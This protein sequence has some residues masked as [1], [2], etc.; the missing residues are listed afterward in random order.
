MFGCHV[1]SLPRRR[2]ACLLLCTLRL[3]QLERRDEY[4]HEL[5]VEV[6]VRRPVVPWLVLNIRRVR[7]ARRVIQRAVRD[8]VRIR[9]RVHRVVGHAGNCGKWCIDTKAF[10]GRHAVPGAII[11]VDFV[12]TAAAVI[13]VVVII[14]AVV[15]F[16][17]IRHERGVHATTPRAGRRTRLVAPDERAVLERKLGLT[18]SE[19]LGGEQPHLWRPDPVAR[20]GAG[21]AEVDTLD[22]PCALLVLAPRRRNLGVHQAAPHFA[23]GYVRAFAGEELARRGVAAA[24]AGVAA[25][26]FAVERVEVPEFLRHTG[27]NRVLAHLGPKHSE[28]SFRRVAGGL[29][30]VRVA[31]RLL[32]RCCHGVHRCRVEHY[33]VV[34]VQRAAGVDVDTE[35]FRIQVILILRSRRLAFGLHGVDAEVGRRSVATAQDV[36][37]AEHGLDWP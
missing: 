4:L 29:V 20:L 32:M 22:P 34:A 12:V 6:H 17:Q 10:A 24:H 11:I 33:L 36:G 28:Y 15:G 1:E 30:L 7:I 25:D 19:V 16:R 2:D 21:L 37:V 13:S 26:D 9:V 27:A 23:L 3:L 18:P 35:G 8:R 14:F 5:D 31:A